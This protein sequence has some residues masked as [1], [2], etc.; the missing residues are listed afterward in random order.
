MNKENTDPTQPVPTPATSSWF[1]GVRFRTAAASSVLAAVS[2]T[3]IG[4]SAAQASTLQAGA[5]SAPAGNQGDSAAH[6]DTAAAVRA[7]QVPGSEER[8]AGVR[9]DLANA[10]AWGSVTADQAERFYAQISAR[11]ARGL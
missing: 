7:V 1:N 3:G 10:V 4:A 9:R 8:L 5:I 2:V 6:T 11:I